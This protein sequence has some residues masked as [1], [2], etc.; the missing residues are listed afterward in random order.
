M[1]ERKRVMHPR[2]PTE[3]GKKKKRASCRPPLGRQQA[4]SPPLL[5]I[6]VRTQ[7]VVGLCAGRSLPLKVGKKS[8]QETKVNEEL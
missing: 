7:H 1:K 4:L 6:E 8:S 5:G 3:G 2:M